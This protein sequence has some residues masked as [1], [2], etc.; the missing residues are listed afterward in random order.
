MKSKTVRVDCDQCEMLSINGIP[1]HES[2]CPNAK[3]RWDPDNQS[4][5][6]QYTC[7]EC[8]CKADIGTECCTDDP[9]I[10]SLPF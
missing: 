3:A 6:K 8:G 1:C 10:D 2:G 7:R 4:W 5:V 9:F